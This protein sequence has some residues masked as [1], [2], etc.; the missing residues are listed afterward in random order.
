MELN[1]H[2]IVVVKLRKTYNILAFK[3][4]LM[5]SHLSNWKECKI[6]KL[7]CSRSNIALSDKLLNGIL[8][9]YI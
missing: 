1:T 6:L 3:M 5:I 2:T 4:A 7:I 9:Y 8:V